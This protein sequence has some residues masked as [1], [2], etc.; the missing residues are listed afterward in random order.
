MKIWKKTLEALMLMIFSISVAYADL[1]LEIT[2]GIDSGRK[3]AVV[4]FAGQTGSGALDFSDI[5]KNDLARTGLF[6]PVQS[7]ANPHA[8][9]EVQAS[10]FPA[11]TEAVV[12]GKVVPGGKGY[13]VNFELISIASGSP[14]VLASM[15]AN[16]TKAQVRQY[17]HRISDV[18]YEKLT[19]TRGAFSTRIAYIKRVSGSRHPFQLAVSDYDG[20]NEVVLV[21]SSQPLMSPS[22]APDGRKLA[23]VSFEQRKSQIYTI[24]VYSKA[25]KLITSFVGLNSTP[26]WSPD[27]SRLALVLSKDGNPEIYILDVAGKRLTRVTNNPAIDTEP[28]WSPDGRQIYFVSERGGAAQIYRVNLSNGGV[29][30]VTSTP[31][32]NLSPVVL[33][34]NSGIIMINQNG[35]F[36]VARQDFNGGFYALSG[37]TLDESPTVAPNGSMII[38]SSVNGGRKSLAL[39]S[40]DGR[41]KAVLKGNSGEIGSPAWSGYLGK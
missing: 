34:D 14:A 13:Q 25:R 21:V 37:T 9:A 6:S 33:P 26:K 16:I 40:S 27:G 15:Q 29:A 18:V 11:G 8:L 38:Y 10:A 31:T 22:W 24:D 3:I 41:Y 35:G 23:Y 36:R 4:P 39:V 5:V 17:G 2:G 1:N 12:V 28:S 7:G 30:R 32:K 20:A 19:G